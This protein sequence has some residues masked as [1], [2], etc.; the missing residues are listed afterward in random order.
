MEVNSYTSSNLFTFGKKK[1]KIGTHLLLPNP[2]NIRLSLHSFPIIKKLNAKR[3]KNV[4]VLK[5]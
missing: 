3:M 2:T 1:M 5:R 4:C